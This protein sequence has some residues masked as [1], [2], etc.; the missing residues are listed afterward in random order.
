MS[1]ITS[2]RHALDGFR[3][4]LTVDECA[5]VLATCLRPRRTGRGLDAAWSTARSSPCSSTRALR[6]SEVASLHWADVDLSDGNNVVVTVRR[7]KAN[8][9]GG[10]A[11]RAT[12][13]RRLRG[14]GPQPAR[15]DLGLSVDQI[16]YQQCPDRLCRIRL[17]VTLEHHG[18]PV[19]DAGCQCPRCG[20]RISDSDR[21]TT[22]TC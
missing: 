18:E 21:R 7:S 4:G 5:T 16:S 9:T 13:G 6:R 3:R 22:H 2:T 15:R 14:R 8:P 17:K 10:R 20:T 1:A 12:S 11:G 19:S